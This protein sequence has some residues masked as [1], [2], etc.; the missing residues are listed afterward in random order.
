MK[1]DMYALISRW[2]KMVSMKNSYLCN[3]SKIVLTDFSDLV[4]QTFDVIKNAKNEYIYPNKYPE[5]TQD[6]FWFL[7]LISSISQ[8]SVD[9]GLVEDYGE[10]KV[11]TA[12]RLIAEGLISYAKWPGD[13]RNENEKEIYFDTDKELNG[14]LEFL[15][16]DYVDVE[17]NE[18]DKTYVYNV[19]NGS[20]E[21][22]LE[23]TQQ[24]GDYE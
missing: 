4:K 21:E 3:E 24:M 23:L 15:R 2:I 19:Y 10:N 9:D 17:E 5:S 18:E 14:I 22:I 11:Y 20:F 12:T 13:M 6:V 7:D 1:T 8:Y 16:S